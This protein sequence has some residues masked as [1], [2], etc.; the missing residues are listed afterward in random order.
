VLFAKAPRHKGGGGPRG[1][2]VKCPI[3]NINPREIAANIGAARAMG[4][5]GAEAVM[6]AAMLAA[7]I[8]V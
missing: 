5:A 1:T 3:G 2:H 7:G 4:C 8:P 6:L